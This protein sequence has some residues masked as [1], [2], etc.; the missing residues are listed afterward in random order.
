MSRDR[1]MRE[2]SSIVATKASAVGWPTPGWSSAGGRPP[3]LLSCVSCPYRLRRPLSSLRFVRQSPPHGGRETSDPLACCKGVI[4]ER[5][6]KRAGQSDPEHDR[7]T[8]D[9]IF[10]AHPLADQLLARAD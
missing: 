1:R 2:G 7:K 6:G 8:T 4:D 9:L 3:R 10:Q 5:G